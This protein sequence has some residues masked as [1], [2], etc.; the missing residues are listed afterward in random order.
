MGIE[1]NILQLKMINDAK[2]T[3]S[4]Q[5]PYSLILVFGNCICEQAVAAPDPL[6]IAIIG[7]VAKGH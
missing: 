1:K 7:Y 2:R 3:L 5:Q 4:H 6:L